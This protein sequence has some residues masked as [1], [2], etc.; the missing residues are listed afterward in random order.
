MKKQYSTGPN[1]DGSRFSRA[2]GC[3]FIFAGVLLLLS[4][5]YGALAGYLPVRQF[6][7]VKWRSVQTADN[8]DRLRMVEWLVRSGKLD[9]ITR[10][11]ALALLGPP[12]DDGYFS[13]WDLVYWV[14]PERGL[15]GI[16]SEWL[17]IRFGQNG[18]VSEYQIVRD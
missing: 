1:I 5:A 8:H 7:A 6:D 13:D 4:V 15:I 14:G 9:G 11:Q 3:A 18:Q 10:A 2:R 16:D 17:V 12:S